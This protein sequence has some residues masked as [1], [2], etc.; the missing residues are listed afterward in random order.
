MS[1][2]TETVSATDIVPTLYNDEEEENNE[3]FHEDKVD[4]LVYDTYNLVACDYHDI[5]LDGDDESNSEKMLEA[6]TRATQLLVNK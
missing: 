4:D 5:V 3:V 2:D 1:G 6:A